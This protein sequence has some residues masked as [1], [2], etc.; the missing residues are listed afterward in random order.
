[1][2]CLPAVL[3]QI[4]NESV[5]EVQVDVQTCVCTSQGFPSPTIKWLLPEDQTE[6]SFNTAVS[7]HTVKST[8]V[9]SLTH[10]SWRPAVCVSGNENGETKG[11]LVIKQVDGEGNRTLGW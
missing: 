5:C 9:L 1:M 10:H 6:F 3:P 11:N 4:L 2:L 8:L 7:H